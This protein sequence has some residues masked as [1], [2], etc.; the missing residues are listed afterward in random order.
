VHR[1]ESVQTGARSGASRSIACPPTMPPALRRR[2]RT[3]RAQLAPRGGS[4]RPLRGPSARR[5][6]SGDRRLPGSRVLHRTRRGSWPPRSVSSSMAGRSSCTRVGVDQ[7]SAH[8]AAVRARARRPCR[9][10]AIASAAAAPAS[11]AMF[12]AERGV[13]HACGRAADIWGREVAL[14]TSISRRRA[15]RQPASSVTGIGRRRRRRAPPG[16]P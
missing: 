8:A 14:E 9:A 6:P 12:A 1:A 5:P 11:G 16:R 3:D 13:A 15:S 4:G 2:R 7:L 10:I